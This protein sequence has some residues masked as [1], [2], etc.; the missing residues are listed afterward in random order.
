[1]PVADLPCSSSFALNFI[2]TH[3]FEA[4]KNKFYQSKIQAAKPQFWQAHDMQFFVTAHDGTD[5]DAASRRA[6]AQEAHRKLGHDMIREG[7]LV[8]S[9]G[10]IDDEGKPTG[11]ARVMK[12]DTR[13]ELEDWLENEPY[14]T[15]NVWQDVVVEQ[16]KMGPAFEWITLEPT[17]RM[18]T[19]DEDI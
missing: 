10:L 1:M 2:S 4:R 13:A 5:A 8:F 19:G 7:K 17:I 12:F 11:S 16:C 14:V 3:Q 18:T 6:A 9:T 15:G